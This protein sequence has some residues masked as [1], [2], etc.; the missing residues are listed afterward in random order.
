MHL[1]S[2]SYR[3][4]VRGYVSLLLLVFGLLTAGVCNDAGRMNSPSDSIEENPFSNPSLSDSPKNFAVNPGI[5]K[6]TGGPKARVTSSDNNKNDF[7]LSFL[8]ASEKQNSSEDERRNP[9]NISV[10]FS[11]CSKGL[12][13]SDSAGASFFCLSLPFFKD[14]SLTLL[15]TVV[16]LH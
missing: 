5:S 7:S 9:Q 2:H 8:F 1:S 10:Y 3:L 13:K 16:F 6:R 11:I 12:L 14:R 4:K 15:S